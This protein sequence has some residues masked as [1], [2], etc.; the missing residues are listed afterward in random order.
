MSVQLKTLKFQDSF[1][2]VEEDDRDMVYTVKTE[3]DEKGIVYVHDSEGN[4]ID[5][6]GDEEVEPI[7]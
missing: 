5:C 2:F 3:V 6:D 4:G 1:R 7:E